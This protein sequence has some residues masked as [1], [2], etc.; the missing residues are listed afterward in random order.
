MQV[1]KP[2][3][4][5]VKL[6][7]TWLKLHAR[8]ILAEWW[9][10]G[11]PTAFNASSQHQGG[12]LAAKWRLDEDVRTLLTSSNHWKEGTTCR[13]SSFERV[14]FHRTRH[15]QTHKTNIH[16]EDRYSQ[17]VRSIM[18]E[19]RELLVDNGHDFCNGGIKPWL[20]QAGRM[21]SH[22]CRTRPFANSCQMKKRSN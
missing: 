6:S 14:R 12:R 21:S 15:S 7:L 4:S 16:S 22:G 18:F 3:K 10:H 11:F 8:R 17:L 9:D 5:T 2:F 19:T 20:H 1:S 13:Q